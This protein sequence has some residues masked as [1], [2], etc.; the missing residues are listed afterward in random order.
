M[1]TDMPVLSPVTQLP[2]SR[3][4]NVV[5]TYDF[6]RPTT[7]VREHSRILELAFETFARQWGTQLT[8][9]IRAGCAVVTEQVTMAT[10]D[11][12]A[13]SL[14]A[15]TAMVLFGLDGQ[16]SRG[17][18]QFPSDAGLCWVTRMLGGVISGPILGRKFT[19]I[20]HALVVRLIEEAL[21]DLRYSF[22]SMLA[23]VPVIEDIHFNSQFAQAAAMQTLMIVAVFT[24]QVGERSWRATIAL[25]AAGLLDQLG[26]SNP[27]SDAAAAPAQ[28]RA[29]VAEI[30][31]E[32]A[33]ALAP[34]CVTPKAILN[35]AVGDV[36]TLPHPITRPFDLTVEGKPVA[37]ATGVTHGSRK[38][39]QIV[40]TEETPR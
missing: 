13:A 25:P 1:V 7:L 17:V 19:P 36:L 9:K 10:Y 28:L 29:Q 35:L 3:A 37:R 27:L 5:E 38:A 32:V 12:Y 6:R 2:A 33:L 14:P 31:V 20:E 39:G 22:G 40:T 4:N 30:P 8:T 16:E 21:E 23:E 18:F 34:V 24:V 11:E 15:S 26:N